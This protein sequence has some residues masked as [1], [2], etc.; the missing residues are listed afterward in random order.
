MQESP[1]LKNRKAQKMRTAAHLRKL[2]ILRIKNLLLRPGTSR[3]IFLP[4]PSRR[5]PCRLS[6]RTSTAPTPHP[7]PQTCS[8]SALSSPSPRSCPRSSA[9]T[10]ASRSMPTSSASW[11]HRL[12]P[13][14]A[15]WPMSSAS[16]NPSRTRYATPTNWSS[17]TTRRNSL[18]T[19]LPATATHFRPRRP[20]IAPSRSLPTPAPLRSIRPSTTTTAA[21]SLPRP[22]ATPWL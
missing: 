22:K 8:Y 7:R 9:Y 12:P 2:R 6:W 17:S 15:N 13:P 16:S 11:L 10:A 4:S 3:R 19:R 18:P 20:S 21:V 14:R 5:L 1:S